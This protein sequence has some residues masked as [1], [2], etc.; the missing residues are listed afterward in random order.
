MSYFDVT[1]T[2]SMPSVAVSP[3]TMPTPPMPPKK[4]SWLLSAACQN[5]IT[6]PPSRPGRIESRPMPASTNSAAAS[7]APPRHLLTNTMVGLNN[8]LMTRSQ[9]STSKSP[10]ATRFRPRSTSYQKT[11]ARPWCC[12]IVLAWTTPRSLKH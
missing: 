1:M 7:A 10:S 3:A 11:F 4:H 12:E 8:M 5:S 6:A 2:A 9:R